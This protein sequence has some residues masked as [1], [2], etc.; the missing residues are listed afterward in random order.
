MEDYTVLDWVPDVQIHS[1]F[2]GILRIY[3]GTK[4]IENDLIRKPPEIQLGDKGL[5]GS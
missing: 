1:N 3:I 4:M 2:Q 5:P